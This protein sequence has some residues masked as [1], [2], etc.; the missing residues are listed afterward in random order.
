MMAN[1]FLPIKRIKRIILLKK[2]DFQKA[3]ELPAK[4][5]SNNVKECFRCPKDK[6]MEDEVYKASP[7]KFIE[8]EFTIKKAAKYL[9]KKVEE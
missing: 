5:F 9:I 6:V 1:L 8:D 2:A 7:Y 3:R 4:V